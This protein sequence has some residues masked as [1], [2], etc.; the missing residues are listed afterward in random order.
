MLCIYSNPIVTLK[1]H[2]NY[3]EVKLY[4]NPV[5]FSVLGML[6][7]LPIIIY[8]KYSNRK[9]PHLMSSSDNRILGNAFYVVYI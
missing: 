5:V 2:Y 7:M 6:S 9:N 4:N 8:S 1:G 3:D